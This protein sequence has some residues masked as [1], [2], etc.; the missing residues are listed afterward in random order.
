MMARPWQG[1]RLLLA[2]VGALVALSYQSKRKT[3]ILVYEVPVS[4]PVVVTTTDFLTTDFNKKNKDPYNFRIVR[5]LKAVKRVSA[6]H[7]PLMPLSG[8]LWVQ[9]SHASEHSLV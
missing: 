8:D 4:D 1:P 7:P 2:I 9:G 3:F 5:V 6:P